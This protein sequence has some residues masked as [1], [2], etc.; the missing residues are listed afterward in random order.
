[1]RIISGLAKGRKLATFSGTGIR[2]TSDRARGAMFSSLISRCGLLTG[3]RVLDLFAGTGALG[4]EALSRG[5]GSVTLVDGGEQA[6][7]IVPAN[8][9][10]CGLEARATFLRGDVA[11]VLPR[12]AAGEGFD[13]IFLD[14]PYGQNLVPATLE[15]LAALQLLRQGGWIC[16]ETGRDEVVPD[17]SGNLVRVDSR[18]YGAAAVHFYTTSGAEE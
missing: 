12:L 15:A 1:M 4:I 11:R 3:Q 18:A 2:P 13:L 10:S 16:A 7:R 6:A 14:P 17:T 8:L 9:Q 5:A